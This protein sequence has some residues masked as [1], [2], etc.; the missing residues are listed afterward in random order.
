M[1][2]AH[3]LTADAALDI[4]RTV[5]PFAGARVLLER[6]RALRA[7]FALS[8]ES[9]DDYFLELEAG[10]PAHVRERR[11]ERREQTRYAVLASLGR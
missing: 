7:W 3:T 1:T 2:I 9:Y 4:R 5:T 11:Q 10:L 8:F 6:L